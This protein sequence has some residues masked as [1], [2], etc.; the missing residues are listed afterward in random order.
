MK[1][2]LSSVTPHIRDTYTCKDTYKD[3]TPL[4]TSHVP[5][6]SLDVIWTSTYVWQRLS[7]VRMYGNASLSF[8]YVWQRLS[9]R[10]SHVT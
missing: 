1:H 10:M 6:L 4:V 9:R 5:P 3:E 2:P 7:L 8:T